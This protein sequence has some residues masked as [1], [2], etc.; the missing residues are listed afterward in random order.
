MP[1]SSPSPHPATVQSRSSWSVEIGRLRFAVTR[2]REVER[3]F[4]AAAPSR[5]AWPFSA[6][7][8]TGVGTVAL[9]V[10]GASAAPRDMI[11]ARYMVSVPVPAAV[12]PH[13]ARRA[14]SKPAGRTVARATSIGLSS[15]ERFDAAD[16]PYVA[17]AMATG[18]FQEWDDALGQH[19]F[20]TAGPARVEDGRYCRNMALLVRLAEGGSR[21]H[22]ATRCTTEPV[23]EPPERSDIEGLDASSTEQP[24]K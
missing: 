1:E 14:S 15:G 22:S 9:L 17:R 19:R 11:A 21:V 23:S 13:V 5:S 6:G 20:L 18:A 10:A 24:R 3:G 16:A 12:V 2:E 7:A 4:P 8:L